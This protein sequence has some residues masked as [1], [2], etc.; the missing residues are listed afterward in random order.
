MM[1]TNESFVRRSWLVVANGIDFI[2]SII[3]QH[4]SDPSDA[5]I[6]N[7]LALGYDSELT[8]SGA[9]RI[10]F[11][12]MGFLL[13]FA[14]WASFFSIDEVTKGNGKVIPSSREQIIQSLDGGILQRINVKEGQIIQAGEIVAQLDSI[15]IASN[16]EEFEA[17]YHALLAQQARLSAEGN[18]SALA[19]SHEL[20]DFPELI[21]AETRLYTSRKA[22]FS[23]A[24]KNIQDARKLISNELSIHSRLAQEGAS[25][26]V[27]VIRLKRQLVDLNMK[28]EELRG[29]Y[30]LRSREELSKVTAEI[31]S[32]KH[33]LRGRS[34]L[35]EKSTLRS[36]VRG[37]VKDIQINTIGGV[38][39]PNGILMHIVPLDD[40]LLIEAQI[41]PRDIAFI[42]PGQKAKV[43]IT[44]YDYAIY[45]SL[46]GEVVTISPDTIKDE[47]K[48][49]LVYYRVL[50]RTDTDHLLNKHKHKLYISPGMVATVEI[51]TG[52]KTVANYLIK[53]FNKVNEALRER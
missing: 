23:D 8:I 3:L 48:P 52:S 11:C 51:V 21:K 53:P 29:N 26:T 43:K 25:S 42:H 44:A 35:V 1:Q 34:D 9:K 30:H 45:G 31:A 19:F 38:I 47:R 16:F 18:D 36:P 27:D 14:L 40:T 33:A 32:L 12:I 20:D 5:V 24:I 37:I 41:L 15:R 6:D 13:L 39:S 7:A 46:D 4:K 17:K 49:D 22:Q 2:R 28:E 10:V 50:I